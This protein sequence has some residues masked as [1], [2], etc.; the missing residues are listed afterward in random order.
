MIGSS[1]EDI[2]LTDR[3]EVIRDVKVTPSDRAFFSEA[4]VT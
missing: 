1:S 4:T 3:F 2:R